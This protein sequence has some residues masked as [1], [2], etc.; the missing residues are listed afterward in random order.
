MRD[1]LSNPERAYVLMTK[2]GE[3]MTPMNIYK[4]LRLHAVRAG[5]GVREAP[6]HWDSAANFQGG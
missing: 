2:T 5:V 4:T 6:S 3:R 1:A